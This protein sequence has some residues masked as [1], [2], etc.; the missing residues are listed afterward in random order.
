VPLNKDASDL[1]DYVHFFEMDL[2][3]QEIARIIG[4]AGQYWAAKTLRNDDMDSYVL[5]KA[6]VCL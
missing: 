2:D 5:A 3:G 6:R 1:P 4:M